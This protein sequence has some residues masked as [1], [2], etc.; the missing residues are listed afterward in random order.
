MFV[1]LFIPL[2]QLLNAWTS[3]YETWYIRVY[4][5]NWTHLSGVLH[6]S[7]PSVYV[8]ACVSLLLLL[9]NDSVKCIP[10]FGA[11]QRLGKH[12]PTATNTS[13]DKRTVGR[14]IFYMVRVLTRE[15][16]W[17]CLCIPVSLLGKE[18]VKMFLLQRRIFGDVFF[19]EVRV[20]IKESR[21]LVLPRTSCLFVLYWI[22][23]LDFEDIKCRPYFITNK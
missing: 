10:P 13:N 5:G 18:S 4:H 9:G 8:S 21:R 6:K 17:V 22:L 16:L 1:C 15:S 12:V 23:W 11:R 7:L 2:C 14:F 20:V 19:Y 3:L